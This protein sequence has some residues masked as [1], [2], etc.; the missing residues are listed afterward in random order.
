[1]EVSPAESA[2]AKGGCSDPAPGAAFGQGVPGGGLL[3]QGGEDALQLREA[4]TQR[5]GGEEVQLVGRV[6]GQ[7]GDEP[8]AP[9]RAVCRSLEG[10]EGEI[11]PCRELQG[12]RVGLWAAS[13]M[14][15]S[16][17]CQDSNASFG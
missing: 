14:G 7:D 17:S 13:L 8:P 1:M 3:Q 15:R 2:G 9:R 10:R 6:K 16:C 11:S 5:G 12:E 4:G